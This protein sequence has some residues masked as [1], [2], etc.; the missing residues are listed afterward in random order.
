MSSKIKT[1]RITGRYRRLKRFF[2][3]S[4]EIRAVSL[5]NAL[6][7]FFSEIGSQ[8]L[9]RTQIEIVDIKEISP[10]EV[11]NAKLRKL[12]MAENPAIWAP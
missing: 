11:K 8:G 10:E 5:E 6:E 12:I 1:Y 9:K 7:K 2:Y 4:K 3:V